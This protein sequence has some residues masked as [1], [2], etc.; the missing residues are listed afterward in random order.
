V[1]LVRIAFYLYLQD[2]V[3]GPYGVDELKDMVTHREVTREAAGAVLGAD[4]PKAKGESPVS[5]PT[6][7]GREALTCGAGDS[8]RHRPFDPF[9]C[10]SSRRSWLMACRSLPG[11]A[12]LL[13]PESRGGGAG[14]DWCHYCA[15][16]EHG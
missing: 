10:L 4:I 15:G 13:S 8:A 16:R 3:A 6:Q 12:D 1:W 7:M 9:L 11:C 5:M 2:R 14:D